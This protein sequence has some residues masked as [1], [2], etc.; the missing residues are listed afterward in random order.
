MS[1]GEMG[2]RVGHQTWHLSLKSSQGPP[3]VKLG[4]G[5]QEE[6][7]HQFAYSE[8]PMQNFLAVHIVLVR[9]LPS[10]CGDGVPDFSQRPR[11]Y[12]RCW[13]V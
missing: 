5:K 1:G 12:C 7:S 4:M 8:F 6:T 10:L 13:A 2:G 11:N 3:E 9:L